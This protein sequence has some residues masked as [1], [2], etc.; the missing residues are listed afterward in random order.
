MNITT[1][2]L[3]ATV[4]AASIAATFAAPSFAGEPLSQQLEERN[5]YTNPMP[6]GWTANAM[7]TRTQRGAL[8]MQGPAWHSQTN[9]SPAAMNSGLEQQR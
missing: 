7:E 6:A 2:L 3:T 4:L 9:V 5:T 1:R 8:Y